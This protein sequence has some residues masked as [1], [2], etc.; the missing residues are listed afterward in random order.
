M[1]E[2]VEGGVMAARGCCAGC[3]MRGVEE[4]EARAR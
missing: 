4:V 3:S 2:V 1:E